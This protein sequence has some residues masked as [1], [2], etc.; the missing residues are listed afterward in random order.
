MR[1]H[2]QLLSLLLTSAVWIAACGG[3]PVP[4]MPTF[5]QDVRPI[6]L[7]RCVRCHGAGGKR[8]GDPT[9][10]TDVDALKSAPN[11]GYFDRFDDPPNCFV[12]DPTNMVPCRGMGYYATTVPGKAVWSIWFPQMPPPPAAGLT[13]RQHEVI[14]KWLASPLP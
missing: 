1:N 5:Q 14:A 8:Q 3:Q 10:V 6:M 2:G 9:S 13:D 12:D 4:D 7:S 11:N